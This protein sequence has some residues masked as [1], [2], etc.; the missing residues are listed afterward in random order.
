MPQTELINKYKG[1]KSINIHQAL[2]RAAGFG[3]IEEVKELI[4]LGAYV[5]YQDTQCETALHFAIMHNRQDIIELLLTAGASPA[6]DDIYGRRALDYANISPNSNIKNLVV[7]KMEEYLLKGSIPKIFKRQSTN[8]LTQS[9]LLQ[10]YKYNDKVVNLNRALHR[11]VETENIQDINEL[12]KIGAD[13]NSFE[14]DGKTPLHRAI[15]TEN[16]EVVDCLVNKGANLNLLDGE[17]SITPAMTALESNNSVIRSYGRNISNPIFNETIIDLVLAFLPFK[18]LITLNFV[19]WS[20][21]IRVSKFISLHLKPEYQDIFGKLPKELKVIVYKRIFLSRAN[22]KISLLFKLLTL[23]LDDRKAAYEKELNVKSSLPN[24][25]FDENGL[26]LLIFGIVSEDVLKDQRIRNPFAV[27]MLD[28]S[29][30]E[31]KHLALFRH[32][33]SIHGPHDEL[34]ALF[35][36]NGIKL[37]KNKI[38]KIEDAPYIQNLSGLMSNDSYEVLEKK[39]IDPSLIAAMCKRFYHF[40]MNANFISFLKTNTI[41]FNKFSADNKDDV[42]KAITIYQNIHFFSHPICIELLKNNYFTLDELVE[43]KQLKEGQL[44]ILKSALDDGLLTKTN[45]KEILDKE[46]ILTVNG[47]QALRE[48]LLTVQQAVKFKTLKD[49]LHDNGL[50]LLRKGILTVEDALVLSDASIGRKGTTHPNNLSNLAILITDTGISALADGIINI[51]EAK[52]HCLAI[53]Q[54][55]G[56][57]QALKEK[58]FS[59]EDTKHCK[60]Y[61]GVFQ[62]NSFKVLLSPPGLD[63]LREGLLVPSDLAEFYHSGSCSGNHDN[64]GTLLTPVG[65]SALRKKLITPKEASRNTELDK[66]LNEKNSYIIRAMELRLIKPSDFAYGGKYSTWANGKDKFS[67]DLISHTKGLVEK[68]MAQFPRDIPTITQETRLNLQQMTRGYLAR[69]QFSLFKQLTTIVNSG[70]VSVHSIKD[71]SE[72][73]N[74]ISV[75]KFDE[76]TKRIQKF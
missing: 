72:A 6:V 38:L 3:S 11:A 49:I 5:N 25:H 1:L 40:F 43:L 50:N 63:A 10:K 55:P 18:D 32:S 26:I 51:E 16:T 45:F 74:L 57:L 19:A 22:T 69:K 61:G 23:K 36:T 12:L 4:Q 47:M 33:G 7:N 48:G 14:I 27:F 34:R 73:Y 21:W 2:I 46:S 31:P 20:M 53:L 71:L 58:L 60:D 8:K 59:L 17:N 41:E 44:Q 68:Y 37:I 67:G 24:N 76:A 52:K 65:L 56:G 70:K 15:I 62:S 39:L 29:L 66:L 75:G 54:I 35:C 13:I 64:L 9:E 28:E 30:L 42:S